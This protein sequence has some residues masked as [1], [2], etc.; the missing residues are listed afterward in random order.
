MLRICGSYRGV[1][2]EFCLVGYGKIYSGEAKRRFGGIYRLNIESRRIKQA[3]NQHEAES[4]QEGDIFLRNVR[5]FWPNYR[6]YIV[7]DKTLQYNLWFQFSMDILL[8]WR[9]T[10][11]LTLYPCSHLPSSWRNGWHLDG[12]MLN[13]QWLVEQTRN[14]QELKYYSRYDAAFISK[15]G[16]CV[17][18]FNTHVVTTC[19]AS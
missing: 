4:K 11:I 16:F 3:R 6:N 10:L 9:S 18:S 17:V 13:K 15:F 7:E 5:Q 14:N 8:F 12:T 1:Y 2:E 19:S